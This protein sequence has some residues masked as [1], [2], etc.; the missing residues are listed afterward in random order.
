M[1][2][3]KTFFE[4]LIMILLIKDSLSK[5][6]CSEKTCPEN[7]GQCIENICLCAPDYTTFYNRPMKKGDKFCNYPFIYKKYVIWFEMSF[8]FGTGHFYAK[9]YF[10]GIIKFILFWFITIVK[11]IFRK[12]IR[13]Y[14]EFI[15]VSKIFYWVFLFLYAVDFLGFS[16]NYYTDG[17]KLPLI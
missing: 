15:K 16:F 6:I 4:I 5:Y 8:P 10:H 11:T 17:N 14:P 13:R 1:V 12:K 3:I 7:F 2:I 9:R